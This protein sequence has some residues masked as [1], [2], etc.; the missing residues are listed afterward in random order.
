MARCC[1][2][3]G[4]CVC[5]VVGSGNTSVTGTGSSQDPFVIE[6]ISVL[7]SQ[8]TEQ[9]DLV[10]VGDGS[11]NNPWYVEVQY[12][13]TA[14]LDGLPDV[15]ETTPPTNG[16]V[17]AWDAAAGQWKPVAPTTAASG[18]VL[19]GNSVQGDGSSTAPLDVTVDPQANLT[20]RTTGLD[21]SDETLNRIVRFYV[22]S[23]SRD[24]DTLAFPPADGTLS[25]IGTN[26]GQ[27]DYWD[28]TTWQPLDNG[29]RLAI[30]PGEML[31]L[32]G[33]YAGGQVYHYVAQISEVTDANGDF[34]VIPAASLVDS[35]GVLSVNV[36][37]LGTANP[38]KAVVWVDSVA[39]A[40]MARAYRIDNGAA[41]VGITADA[42]VT[43]TLY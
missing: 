26:L 27:L 36:Q 21:L 23:A 37:E 22:D 4:S 39:G 11:V 1:G 12:A 8:G 30:Q 17:L 41:Y 31:Q 40:V 2:S 9:F 29:I 43:A 33:P 16:Q 38:Y 10:I 7:T 42:V 15:D 34:E 25:M 19:T 18:S 24:A 6:G 32:S 28:G 35:A 3:T 14:S 5:K 20:I 13:P